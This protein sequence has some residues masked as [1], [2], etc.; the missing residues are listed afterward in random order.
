MV[1]D[2]VA[3]LASTT[4]FIWKTPILWYKVV[5]AIALLLLVCESVQV[6]VQG[7]N[8]TIRHRTLHSFAVLVAV[9]WVV[10]EI[11]LVT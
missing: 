11:Q 7:V 4:P 3:C 9:G 10:F 1:G 8:V 6:V 2:I 5:F